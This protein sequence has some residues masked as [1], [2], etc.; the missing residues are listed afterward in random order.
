MTRAAFDVQRRALEE[1]R[2]MLGIARE[3]EGESPVSWTV[4]LDRFDEPNFRDEG[5]RDELLRTQG[6]VV[7]DEAEADWKEGRFVGVHIASL[8]ATRL[9]GQDPQVAVGLEMGSIFDGGRRESGV[10]GEEESCDGRVGGTESRVPCANEEQAQ[11]HV[12]GQVRTVR[13]TFAEVTMRD[14]K[15]TQDV[16]LSRSGHDHRKGNGDD[17]ETTSNGVAFAF[18]LSGGG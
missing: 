6:V 8:E 12:R 10:K 3:V 14:A 13:D 17:A 16:D 1:A 9:H 18:C 7:L 2:E 11:G 5:G 15:A 4:Y